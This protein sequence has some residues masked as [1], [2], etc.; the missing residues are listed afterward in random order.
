MQYDKQYSSS[1]DQP[2]QDK[3]DSKK[4]LQTVGI[5]VLGLG[6]L[7]FIDKYFSIK[8]LI[9]FWPFLLVLIGIILI[10]KARNDK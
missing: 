5:I 3:K 9:E 6:L 7:F 4:N 1:L 2:E 8:N 10:W